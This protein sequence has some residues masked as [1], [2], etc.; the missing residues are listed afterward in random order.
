MAEPQAVAIPTLAM[1]KPVLVPAEQLIPA[2]RGQ[3][4]Y[5]LPALTSQPF[6]EKPFPHIQS[7]CGVGVVPPQ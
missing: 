5:S 7:P 2:V 3:H 4:P 1:L 6:S